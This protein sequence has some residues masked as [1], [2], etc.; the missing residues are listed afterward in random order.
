MPPELT[1]DAL[2]QLVHRFYPSGTRNDVPRYK[3][4]EEG[5]R[6][7]EVVLANEKPTQAWK[8]FIQRLR[9]EFPDCS[10]WDTT[11]PRHDPCYGV[12]VS[13]PGFVTGDPRCEEVV[14]LLSQ[15][16]PVYALYVS[17]TV[18]KGPGLPREGWLRFPPFP[19]EF[20]ERET[21]LASLIESTFG[22]T[23]LSNE[24]LFTPVPDLVPR[25]AHYGP[26]EAQLIDLLFTWHRW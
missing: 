19:P 2:V 5:Q 26:G 9:G 20:Q 6:L 25:T 22:F 8:D 1:A 4:S 13:Q 12:R 23:R 11:I 3:E 14:C 18:N 10:P 24:V 15:I 21:R 7:T 17:L 16:A